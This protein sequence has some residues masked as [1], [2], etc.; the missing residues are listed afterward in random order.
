MKL[1]RKEGDSRK[2]TMMLCLLAALIME[3]LFITL[4]SQ[5][6]YLGY[7]LTENYLIVPALLFLGCGLGGQLSGFAKRRVFLAGIAISWFALVQIIHKLS[8]MDTHPIATVFFVYLMAFPFAS[9]SEDRENIGIR[10]IGGMFL[11]A[12]LVLVGYTGLLLTGMAPASLQQFMFWDG[13]RLHV[14]WHPNMSASIFMI[15]IAA[16]AAFLVQSRK[17]A[18]KVLLAV[19]IALQFASMALTNCRTTL[20]M[21]SLLF[22]GFLFFFV[23]KGNWKQLLLGLLTA[24]IV[25][26]GAF[27]ISG[28]IYQWNTDRLVEQKYQEMLA[29]VETEETVTVWEENVPNE[30]PAGI[31]KEDIVLDSDNEQGTLVNDMRTLNGRTRIW[32]CVLD[33]VK[34]SKILALFGTEYAGLAISS[35]YGG[36]IYHA[37]NSWLEALL[38]M[39]IPG[40][41]MSLVF[42]ALTVWSAAK[43]VFNR[44]VELWK[45]IVAMLTVCLLGAGFLEPY[46]FIT[47]VYYHVTDFAFFFLAGYLDYWANAEK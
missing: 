9:V 41:L 21:T 6:S 5:F 13:A 42:T 19:A 10:W 22:G 46:L 40:L 11:V 35:Y 17:P 28:S 29:A 18:V 7:Y 38:R 47:N 15:G 36:E 32:G 30:Q 37:H 1:F 14:F 20:L 8:G 16:A 25:F 31:N 3:F 2:N 12:S 43:L 44:S 26:V 27:K 45:K 33:A 34:D 23:Y 39:G 24:V 4:E